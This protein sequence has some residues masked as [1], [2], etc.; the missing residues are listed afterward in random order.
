MEIKDNILV[1]VTDDDINIDGTFEVPSYITEIGDYAFS[2]CYFLKTVIIPN[3]VMKIGMRVFTWCENLTDITIPNSVIIVQSGIFSYCTSLKE[4]SLPDNLSE[5]NYE[6]FAQ[7]ENLENITL[8]ESVTKI[9][10]SAFKNCSKLKHIN[11]PSNVVE[12]E[13]RAFAHC[14]SLENINLP[15]SIKF[16]DSYA[17]LDCKSLESVTISGNITAIESNVFYG[18]DSLKN[19]T[20]SGKLTSDWYIY[21]SI[22]SLKNINL[23]L[24]TSLFDIYIIFLI[25][26]SSV[27]LIETLTIYNTKVDL[28]HIKKDLRKI[29]EEELQ[30]K[31]NAALFDNYIFDKKCFKLSEHKEFIDKIIDNIDSVGGYKYD[32]REDFN[33]YI[34]NYVNQNKPKELVEVKN[35]QDMLTEIKSYELGNKELNDSTKIKQYGEELE[36]YSLY[37]AKLLYELQTNSKSSIET[38]NLKKVLTKLTKLEERNPEDLSKIIERTFFD[39][40]NDGLV[41]NKSAINQIISFLRY[42]VYNLKEEINGFEMLKEV[43]EV[44][45]DKLQ[46]C[47]ENV[48][49]SEI[50]DERDIRLL[51]IDNNSIKNN[52][53]EKMPL[54]EYNE[55]MMKTLYEQINNLM[56]LNYLNIARLREIATIIIPSLLK[57][58][59]SS[60]VILKGREEVESL[61][62]ICKT[63]KEL[64]DIEES[65]VNEIESLIP[66]EEDK[67]KVYKK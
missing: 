64:L 61:E 36:N 50:S 56:E 33:D 7:C 47:K 9:S 15:N 5:I 6:M 3:S 51:N 28:N 14:E 2:N 20:V 54:L 67:G 46:E 43:I 11:I 45:Q 57:N 34:K 62:N 21:L 22:S 40:D 18:C 37:I 4:V 19:I 12:I 10:E 26:H 59:T 60:K 23:N 17:F 52:I 30:D 24:K 41:I 13:N 65:K 38:I 44:C 27:F 35:V 55:I 53:S 49:N 25:K 39:V 42:K 31:I 32:Y 66:I 16:I 63:F 1:K 58:S 8:P 48:K 29:R